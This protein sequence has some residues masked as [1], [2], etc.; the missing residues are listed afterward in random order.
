MY[1]TVEEIAKRLRCSKSFVYDAIRDGRLRCARLGKGQGLKRISEEDFLTFLAEAR[2]PAV[3][4]EKR[5][6]PQTKLTHLS[7]S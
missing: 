5:V 1:W 4:T 3:E 2:S 7:L 6:M